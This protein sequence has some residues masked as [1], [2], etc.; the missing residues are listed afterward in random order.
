MRKQ[1][2]IQPSI[3]ILY[4]VVVSPVHWVFALILSP[5]IIL[6]WRLENSD[7]VDVLGGG[8]Q[9][10]PSHLQWEHQHPQCRR[11]RWCLA[12]PTK[13]LVVLSALAMLWCPQTVRGLPG[14]F[15]SYK[16]PYF[17]NLSPEVVGSILS[18]L[19]QGRCLGIV[20]HLN[21][22]FTDN[23]GLNFHEC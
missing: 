11:S 21:S 19:L 4:R 20:L 14:K 18:H 10:S 7:P 23:Q 15:H 9:R 8:D 3:D 6:M 16:I 1:K 17:L 2:G 13:L 5:L 12:L 22:V